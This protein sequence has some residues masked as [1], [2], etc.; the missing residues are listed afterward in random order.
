[1]KPLFW[2]MPPNPD[3]LSVDIF[4][5]GFCLWMFA[6]DLSEAVQKVTCSFLRRRCEERL[7]P[8]MVPASVLAIDELPLT[9]SGKAMPFW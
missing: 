5:E 3:D 1:M 9:S 4:R 6:G 7:P 8:H 2:Q